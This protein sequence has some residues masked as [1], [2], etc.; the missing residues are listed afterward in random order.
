MT[1]FALFLLFAPS[2]DGGGRGM[3]IFLFQMLAFV[4]IIYFLMIRPKIQQEKRH[5]ERLGQIKRGDE[6]VTTGGIMGKVVHVDDD[7]LTIK[8]GESRLIVQRGRVGEVH[9]PGTEEET[10]RS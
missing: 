4:A 3:G 6:I 9:T 1:G 10:K 5:R 7:K 8:S 2:G